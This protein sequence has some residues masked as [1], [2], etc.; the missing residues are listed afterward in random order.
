MTCN[1][2]LDSFFFISYVYIV[3][4]LYYVI[5]PYKI[6]CLYL[7]S[8]IQNEQRDIIS[9]DVRKSNKKSYL[10]CSGRNIWTSQN[11]FGYLHLSWDFHTVWEPLKRSDKTN[12]NINKRLKHPYIPLH[13][14]TSIK[15]HFCLYIFIG[16]YFILVHRERE[17]VT[18]ICLYFLIFKL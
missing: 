2:Q 5:F 18:L 7:S 16:F 17:I 8:V 10:L 14:G 9:A 12:N 11:V 15:L 3:V 13:M 6:T 1:V 4:T